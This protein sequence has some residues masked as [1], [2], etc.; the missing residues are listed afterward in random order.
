VTGVDAL[1]GTPPP[2]G[3]NLGPSEAGTPPPAG[4]S[5]GGAVEATPPAGEIPGRD[6]VATTSDE[7]VA[8]CD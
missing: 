4:G 1:A 5:T 7:A 2:A 6:S 3:E 8:G